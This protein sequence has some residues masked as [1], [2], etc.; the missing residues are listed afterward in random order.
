M[1]TD[2]PKVEAVEKSNQKFKQSYRKSGCCSR[3]YFSYCWTLIDSMNKNDGKMTEE[4]IED[5]SLDDGE[6][7][8]LVEKLFSNLAYYEEDLNKRA[9]ANESKGGPPLPADSYYKAVVKAVAR[10]FVRDIFVANLF[11]IAG[12]LCAIGFTTSL[13]YLI[14]YIKDD[15]APIEEG[16]VYLVIFSVLMY[17]SAMCKNHYIFKGALI[18]VQMRKTL[19]AAMYQKISKLSMKSLTQTNSGKLITIISGDI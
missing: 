12:E 18:A 3:F 6:T 5:M 11:C 7:K 4:M 13:I 15:D 8:L 14:A 9:E 17:L 10:T 2:T 16:I 19:V 1:G